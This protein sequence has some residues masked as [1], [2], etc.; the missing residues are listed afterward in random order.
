MIRETSW[1]LWTKEIIEET[2]DKT[3]ERYW[4]EL[5]G[6]I[7]K[8]IPTR[9]KKESDRAYYEANREKVQEINKEWLEKNKEKYKAYKKDWFQKN[10]EKIKERRRTNYGAKP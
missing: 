8:V 7:N 1:E 9:P 6:N 3:R 5:I 2:D 4:I 10:K